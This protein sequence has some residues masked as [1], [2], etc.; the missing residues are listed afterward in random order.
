MDALDIA[1]TVVSALTIISIAAWL[2]GALGRVPTGPGDEVEP[3]PGVSPL[4]HHAP[5]LEDGLPME[6][7]GRTLTTWSVAG[8]DYF[9]IGTDL[10]LEE[11]LMVA[12]ELAAEGIDLD[13]IQL[14]IAGR[15]DV[16]HDP[17]YFIHALRFGSAP[18][19]T[20][21]GGAQG[22]YPEPGA[23]RH[24]LIDG[25]PVRVGTYSMVEQTE[26]IRGKPYV[27]DR[28]NVRFTVTTDDVRWAREALS[29]LAASDPVPAV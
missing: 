26:H 24:E 11:T 9:E 18:A 13:E 5:E 29:K 19:E 23:W 10:S 22:P 6:V 21:P 7:G 28:G 8:M 1:K 2:L 27:W 25:R 4:P 3:P 15:S 17:P 20:L 12:E 16:E 14:A